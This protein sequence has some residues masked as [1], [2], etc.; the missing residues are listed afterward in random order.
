MNCR[1]QCTINVCN[2]L[3]NKKIQFV[4]NRSTTV[5]SARIKC[6]KVDFDTDSGNFI[7][8]VRMSAQQYG[9]F[10]QE[11]PIADID[12]LEFDQEAGQFIVPVFMS[13]DEYRIYAKNEQFPTR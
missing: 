5:Q 9:R 1:L 2:V 12:S 13:L 11:E 7:V 10:A 6:S 4:I 3:K 8:P